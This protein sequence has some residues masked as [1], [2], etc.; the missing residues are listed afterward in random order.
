MYGSTTI[1]KYYIVRTNR[2]AAVGRPRCAG[3]EASS[4][5]PLGV[6]TCRRA[7]F[8]RWQRV[9][10]AGF[11]ARPVCRTQLQRAARLLSLRGSGEVV[12]RM[13]VFCLSL[14]LASTWASR[15]DD[16]PCVTWVAGS[17]S[18]SG[19]DPS[20]FI[21]AI[22]SAWM[23]HPVGACG[24]PNMSGSCSRCVAQLVRAHSMRDLFLNCAN[25]AEQVLRPSWRL[26]LRVHISLLCRRT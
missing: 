22:Y 15:P 13:R 16:N 26:R 17:C 2:A 18:V 23:W 20:K 5:V 8:T 12:G 21:P 25:H 10:R 3:R 6:C 11:R 1:H 14:S 7:N 4:V 24:S 19:I 9:S